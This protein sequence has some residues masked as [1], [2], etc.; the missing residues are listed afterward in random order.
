MSTAGVCFPAEGFG[1]LNSEGR[2]TAR[3]G[4]LLLLLL[5]FRLTNGVEHGVGTAH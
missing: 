2:P 3:Q 5:Q 1:S 4:A